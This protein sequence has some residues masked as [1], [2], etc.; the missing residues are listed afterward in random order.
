MKDAK[1]P[2]ENGHSQAFR[3]ER[4]ERASIGKRKL[5]NGK[6]AEIDRLKL[7]LA[8]EEFASELRHTLALASAAG[9]IASP[10]THSRLLEMIVETAAHVISA[11]AASLFLI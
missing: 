7:R 9:T 10:V 8:D 5:A 4:S 2:K 3:P 1:D 6:Q 11:Q